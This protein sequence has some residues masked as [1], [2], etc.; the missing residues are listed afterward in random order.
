MTKEDLLAQ[1][2]IEMFGFEDN[3]NTKLLTLSQL[4][5]SIRVEGKNGR[6]LQTRPVQSWNAITY[7]LDLLNQAN[8]NFT[9]E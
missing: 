5:Q 1:P 8:M 7:I 6:V 2:E 9:L 3:A 4:E